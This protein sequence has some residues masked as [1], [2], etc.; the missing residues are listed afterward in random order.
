MN[1][2]NSTAIPTHLNNVTES[3]KTDTSFLTGNITP[4]PWYQHIRTKPTKTK[5]NG[6]PDPIAVAILSDIMYWYRPTEVRDEN[7]GNVIGYK[8]KFKAD[9]LQKNYDS[10]AELFGVSKKKTKQSFDLLV[11]LGLLTREFRT[12]D[13]DNGL[14]LG[15]VMFIEPIFPMVKAISINSDTPSLPKRVIGSPQKRVPPSPPKGEGHIQRIRSKTTTTTPPTA[16]EPKPETEA[17]PKK[18]SSFSSPKENSINQHDLDNL[19]QSVPQEKRS[20]EVKHRL[21]L[22]L[23]AGLTMAY[24]LDCIAYS[25]D[26]SNGNYVGHLGNCIDGKWPAEGYHQRSIEDADRERRK[27][28]EK[29]KQQ[30][31]AEA[32][33][34]AVKNQQKDIE[35]LLTQVDVATLDAYIN[36][37]NLNTI[38]RGMF[39]R[40]KRA[41]LRRAWVERFMDNK[42]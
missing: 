12:V 6:S 9:K 38:E 36:G 1:A 3:L 41:M 7:T 25:N 40:G 21:S 42:E 10:Y 27:T 19:M 2:I 23:M 15:N 32:E 26:K 4:I 8:Q 14:K 20:Q 18:S 17:S 22:A 39:K 13:L 31:K 28:Q 11:D 24:L 30:A 5:P 35:D 16:A 33:K 37:Q 29:Q 34:Q